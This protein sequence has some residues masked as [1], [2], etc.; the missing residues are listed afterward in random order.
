MEDFYLNLNSRTR[1]ADFLSEWLGYGS[2]DIKAK[3]DTLLT[4]YDDGKE[5][6]AADMADVVRDLAIDIWPIR[7]AL[8]R[9]FTEEG[10]MVEWDLVEK[11]VTRSTAHLME[12]F[13]KTSGVN[14]LDDLFNHDD[15][16]M[17][18][19]DAER[20]E[21]E[22]VRIHIRE[23]Y[24]K[25]HSQNLEKLEQEGRLILEQFVEEMEKMRKIAE[26]LPTMLQD[27]LYS[28][29]SRFEDRTLYYGEHIPMELL[30]EELAYYTEQKELPID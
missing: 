22:Q 17:S 11:A 13:R 15:F 21:I 30:N 23:D 8:N 9:F 27:E 5:L 26:G 29:I 6:V 19:K 10:G 2:K 1:I 20:S 12:R 18:F 4:A 14:S 7:F 28:K 25:N 3:A 16:D 24:W